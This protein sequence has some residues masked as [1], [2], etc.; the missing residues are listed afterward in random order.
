MLAKAVDQLASMLNMP[1]PFAS[2]LAPTGLCSE[3]LNLT[4]TKKACN[5]RPFFVL[6]VI[7]GLCARDRN[8]W[9]CISSKR[10]KVRWNSKVKRPPV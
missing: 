9:D 6:R 7:Y 4:R 3:L 8:S 10:L 2:K 5:R 1:P